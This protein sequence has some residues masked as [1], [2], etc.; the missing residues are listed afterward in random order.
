MSGNDRE[1]SS[2][3]DFVSKV[4]SIPEYIYTEISPVASNSFTLSA[5]A[6][7][8][9]TCK[10]GGGNEI[11]NPSLTHLS[12][13]SQTATGSV[14]AGTYFILNNCRLN[15]IQAVHGGIVLDS[16]NNAL[17]YSNA[18]APACLDLQEFLLMD[19]GYSTGTTAIGVCEGMRRSNALRAATGNVDMA[20]RHNNTQPRLQ[21][22]DFQYFQRQNLSA[23]G[24]KPILQYKINL[25]L[26][27]PHTWFSS[28]KDYC[29]GNRAI[30]YTFRFAPAQ[31]ISFRVKFT[32]GVSH[33]ASTAVTPVLSQTIS[34]IKLICGMEN[35][36]P[37]ADAIIK[38][39][40]SPG[41]YEYTYDSIQGSVS[42]FTGLTHSPQLTINQ[43]SGGF[44]KAVYWTHYNNTTT[45]ASALEHNN[46]A[47]AT[48]G[49]ISSFRILLNGRRI[50][51]QYD[52]SYTQANQDGFKI[53]KPRFA[54]SC[55]GQ[56]R[57][58]MDYNFVWFSP[59]SEMSS[60]EMAKHNGDE[61]FGL[62]LK[63][64]SYNY[65]IQCAMAGTSST[66]RWFI[67]GIYTRRLRLASNSIPFFIY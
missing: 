67:W 11:P 17:E 45:G 20:I 15:S 51:S 42:T 9:V 57:D 54:Q 2:E 19:L 61:E 14:S 34:N 60:V 53:L 48:T 8:T 52:I 40:N 38:A 56:C 41:G 65:Q 37:I 59:F 10:V 28:A 33:P 27:F 49:M 39:Y 13:L 58:M 23:A 66:R 16:I 26:M 5:T 3:V 30:E 12:F 55:I 62:P 36:R 63:N 18:V 32:G 47:G 7:S 50:D 44:L 4:V 6:E 1:V 43:S 25:G 46:L 21:Y 24:A 22:T 29:T 31:N 64:M 35:N